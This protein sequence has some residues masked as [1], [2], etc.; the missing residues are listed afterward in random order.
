MLN[1]ILGENR[2]V[3]IDVTSKKNESFTIARADV[4][5][6][7]LEN[8]RFVLEAEPECSIDN[9]GRRIKIFLAPEKC[10]TYIL[11]ATMVIADEQIV[12]KFEIT[13]SR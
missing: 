6:L 12:R 13:V 4:A 8:N 1:L 2:H 7:H 11:K 10:G 5:L 9:F 3:F